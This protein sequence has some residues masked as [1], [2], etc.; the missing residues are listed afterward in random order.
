M[1]EVHLPGV[2]ISHAWGD[3]SRRGQEALPDLLKAAKGGHYL[4]VRPSAPMI[5]NLRPSAE[6]LDEIAAE[7]GI[8]IEHVAALHDA[9]GSWAELYALR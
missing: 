2:H 6:Q 7:L 1:L 5:Y 8:E 4:T 3:V 9:R